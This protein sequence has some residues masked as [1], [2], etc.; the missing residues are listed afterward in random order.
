[1]NLLI[2][3]EAVG[4]DTK[5]RTAEI[6]ISGRSKEK[7]YDWIYQ[8]T[9]EKMAV[10]PGGRVSFSRLSEEIEPGRVSGLR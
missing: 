7:I 4:A 3:Q 6:L 2:Q 10:P 9:Y 1:M 8:K 5:I